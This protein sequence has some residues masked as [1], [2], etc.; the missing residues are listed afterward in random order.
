MSEIHEIL[1]RIGQLVRP[2]ALEPMGYKIESRSKQSFAEIVKNNKTKRSQECFA[3]LMF[4]PNGPSSA[5]QKCTGGEKTELIEC[6]AST[7]IP[8]K[9]TP[10]KNGEKVSEDSS[11]ADAAVCEHE[12][13]PSDDEDGIGSAQL[14]TTPKSTT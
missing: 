5:S 11:N 6:K 3:Q 12:Q 9:S 4:E 13:A 1:T 14:T 10:A 8:S 7:M 2:A